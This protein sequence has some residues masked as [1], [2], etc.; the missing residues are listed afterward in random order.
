MTLSAGDSAY[1]HG[2]AGSLYSVALIRSPVH[3]STIG[4]EPV[5]PPDI[6]LSQINAAEGRVVARITSELERALD[7]Q[8][9]VGTA[10]EEARDEGCGF[11]G[12]REWLIPVNHRYRA[13]F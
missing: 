6:D 9:P 11:S 7:S 1:A 4:H 2:Q 5:Y 3:R 13:S 12:L 10:Q 8:L